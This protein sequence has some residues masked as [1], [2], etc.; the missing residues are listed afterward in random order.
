VATSSLGKQAI[1]I[2]AGMSGLTA[3]AALA[4]FFDNVTV[5][6]RDTLPPGPE[7]RAGTPQDLHLHVLLGGGL[8]A[9][10]ELF[11]EF[12][13]DLVSAGAVSFRTGLDVRMERPGYDPFPQR[14]LGWT[15]YA[16][17]RPLGEF[18]VR[19]SL[20]KCRNVTLRDG[21]RV[22]QLVPAPDGGAIAG[23]KLQNRNG[24]EEM[25]EADLLVDASA[26]GMLTERLLESLGQPM[27]D[28]TRVGIDMKYSTAL[29]A[30]PPDAPSG[31]KGVITFPSAPRTSQGAFLMPMEGNR[32]IVS[33]GAAHA[34]K[35]PANADEFLA[36]T[37]DLRTQTVFEAIR[38]ATRL[39]EI[40]R[41]GFPASIWRHFER[42]ENFP[43]GLLV[44]GDAICRFNPVH[45]QGMSV[46]AQEA[47]LLLR[48]LADLSPEPDPLSLL[49]T[50]FFHDV[51][52]LIETPWLS[53]AIPDFIYPQTVGQRPPDFEK[54][55][56]FGAA[57]AKLAFRD[58]AVHKLMMEVQ[59]LRKPRSAYRD[60]QLTHT[61][62]HRG[63]SA[64][65]E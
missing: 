19:Q 50:R 34:E 6:E 17:S 53:A 46:A 39:S 32:W 21:C 49:A 54:S 24:L 57:L 3:A 40:Y 58:P 16:M 30:I 41:F 9:L 33:L 51:A 23:V 8:D 44:V 65:Q 29:F 4:N 28:E 60:L 7:H 31:W 10:G 63:S 45:G 61:V 43:R 42:L 1:V 5:L 27:P 62:E 2:G 15:G 12:E 14:D 55:L 25:L 59:H 13:G 26:R 35:M 20:M 47:R 56:Q 22:T 37:K 38:R 64:S 36:F 48:V 52:A 18:V 11:P